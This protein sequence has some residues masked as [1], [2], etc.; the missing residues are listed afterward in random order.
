MKDRF[1]KFLLQR[2]RLFQ[3]AATL[4]SWLVPNDRLRLVMVRR[5]GLGDRARQCLDHYLAGSG[6]PLTVTTSDLL[7]EDAGV[8]HALGHGI[9]AQRGDGLHGGVISV[10]QYAFANID[11]RCALGSVHF[12]WKLDD[13][14]LAIWFDESYRWDPAASRVTRIF[15]QAAENMKQHGAREFQVQGMPARVSRRELCT[16]SGLHVPADRLY[17]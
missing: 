17:M 9:L 12:N 3:T 14:R 6:K 5:W 10:P 4:F 13:S 11:W 15:H 7:M 16:G 8:R 1:I 2:P